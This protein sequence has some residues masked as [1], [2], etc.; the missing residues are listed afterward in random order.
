MKLKLDKLRNLLCKHNI[1]FSDDQEYKLLT[2]YDYLVRQNEVMNL[3][4]ITDFNEVE[5]KHFIDSISLALYINLNNID[6]MIDIG[7][8][9]GFPGIPLKIMFP[10]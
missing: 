1:M 2:Y 10:H 5:I 3:T 4:A 8:G 7:T 6:S 9:A